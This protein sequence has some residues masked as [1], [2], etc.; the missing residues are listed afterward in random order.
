MET[1]TNKEGKEIRVFEYMRFLDSFKF[2]PSSLAALANDLPNEKFQLLKNHFNNSSEEDVQLLCEKGFYPYS[3]ISSFDIFN[4][5]QLPPIE[6]WKN[7]LTG[8]QVDITKENWDHANKVFQTFNCVNI[9]DYHDLYLTTDV[10]ILACVFEEFRDKSY[11]TYGL[12]SCYHYSAS[13]LSGD[14]FLLLCEADIDLLTEREHLEFAE[15]MMRGGMASVYEQ[16][17][18]TAN[19]KFLPESMFNSQRDS[20]FIAMFDSNNLYG[21]IMEKQALPLNSFSINTSVSLDEILSTEDNAQY[22]FIVEVDLHYPSELHDSHRDYPLAP[23][24]EAV[25]PFWLSQ[26]QSGLL[27]K[28][29]VRPSGK[30][31]K[32]LQTLYDKKRYTLHYRTL[33]LYV[34]LGLEVTKLHRVLQFHQAAWMKPY[35]TKNTELRQAA[36]NK[37]DTSFYKLMNNSDYG[38]TCE[39]K[40][41]R[42]Q[43]KIVRNPSENLHLTAKNTFKTFK[44]FGENFAALSFNQTKI[45]WNKPTIIGATI[46]DL[47]KRE[48]FLFHYQTMRAHF[49]CRLLYSDTDSL[50][51]KV[52]SQDFY[53]DLAELPDE[54]KDKFDFSNYSP[55]NPLYSVKNKLVTLKFKDEFG[56]RIV[57]EFC[58]LK[59]KLY[60]VMLQGKCTTSQPPT[61][62]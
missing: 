41:N 18:C 35:I 9:G 21:G 49:D 56:G 4:E 47:S 37:F 48:M 61:N 15:N 7:T 34:S 43:V 50:V 53:K 17:L 6:F 27:E 20:T 29:N 36:T 10:L 30:V 57:E 51:Y 32:L 44:L 16:R 62:V 58:A 2:L 8:C 24:K 28:L 3:Y 42:S 52:V 40:R 13:N 5:T 23:T 54:A 25:D 12:D 26:Y 46:L 59:P 33:Q 55:D 1:F 60:S 14:A 22:G 38:K 39:S 19:N 45:Y 11:K 31:K